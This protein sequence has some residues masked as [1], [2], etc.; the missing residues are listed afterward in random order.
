VSNFYD[1]L[2]LEGAEQ[3]EQLSRLAFELRED[4][5]QLLGRHGVDSEQALLALVQQGAVPEHPAY[6]DYLGARVLADTREAVRNQ[7]QAVMR[8]LAQ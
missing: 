3:L 4:R 6:D 2:P 8:E 7:L 1:E 5:K